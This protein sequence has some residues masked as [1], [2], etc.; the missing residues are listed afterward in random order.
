M[1]SQSLERQLGN[2]SAARA[3]FETVLRVRADDAQVHN[4]FANLLREAE[5]F[6]A[7]IE[8][9]RRA[10]EIKPDYLDALINL[11]LAQKAIGQ[12]VLARATFQSAIRLA[13]ES[14]KAWQ[15]LGLAERELHLLDD[16]AAS[17]D[18]ACALDP[19]NV[20]ALHARALTEAERGRPATTFYARAAAAAPT[21]PEI[22]MGYAVAMFEDGAPE[23]ALTKLENLTRHR[24]GYIK[25][26]AALA[27]MRWQSGDTQTFASSF[28]AAL[29]L[30]PDD[31]DLTVA[32]FGTLMR[33]GRYADVLARLPR[34]RRA[35]D[36]EDLFDRY[37]AVCASESGDI[38][39]AE[40]AFLRQEHIVDR[41]LQVARVRHLLRTH[42]YSDAAELAERVA[43][44]PDGNEAWPYLGIAW[45]CLGDARSEWLDRAGAFVAH[46]DLEEIRP[47]LARI[48]EVLR[49][50][51]H[52]RIHPFD[53]SLRGGTQ[54]D[55]NLLLRHEPE[56][57]ELRSWIEAGVARY[58]ARLPPADPRHPFLRH[59]G[60]PAEFI[61][62][63]SVRLRSHGFHVNHMHPDAWISC[64]LYVDIPDSIGGDVRASGWLAHHR[65]ASAGTGSRS[66]PAHTR[67][68]AAG[69]ARSVPLHHLARHC[70]LRNRRATDGRERL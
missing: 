69:P 36:A 17:L 52:G 4:N 23:H 15:C 19:A 20:R 64:C 11:G 6:E 38:D 14:R 55:G 43:R 8:H 26:H 24:P 1:R 32:C 42:R 47:K 3:H 44:E 63:Y 56:L 60:K 30:R 16:A 54:T 39:R 21:D 58:V 50:I 5:D 35:I 40:Q 29:A 53:Q 12:A 45:R 2:L 28:D 31:I 25:G 27:Q 22:A 59:V 13:P 51:H 65:R 61:G 41:G 34:A 57:I 46:F 33:A 48:T 68:T 66:A 37:E 67:P 62:S 9:Y 7:A 18:R 10:L 49:G 70:A